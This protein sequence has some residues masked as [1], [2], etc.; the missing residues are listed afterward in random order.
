M[1][2]FKK[3]AFICFITG[4]STTDLSAQTISPF[5]MTITGKT[6]TDGKIY[7]SYTLGEVFSGA[8]N[9][10]ESAV[11]GILQPEKIIITSLSESNK[12][13]TLIN[14][15]P[16]PTL[17]ILNISDPES[18]V[19]NIV[20]CNIFGSPVL[21][22]PMTEVI[23]LESLESGMYTI[24]MFDKNNNCIYTSKISRL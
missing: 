4:V 2:T 12:N 7:V 1:K 17:D 3:L 24:Q 14:F 19:Y 22:S 16:N 23:S 8:I 11:I 6:I 20:I 15:Y 21:S 18:K 13:E 10:K 5:G 9:G